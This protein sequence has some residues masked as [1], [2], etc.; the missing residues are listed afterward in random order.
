MPALETRKVV[1]S[2]PREGSSAVARQADAACCHWPHSRGSLKDRS[3]GDAVRA[4]GA[5]L[6]R[7]RPGTAHGF[8]F[9]TL[10]DETGT[11]Q[12]IVPPDLFRANRQLIVTSPLLI[13]DGTLKNATA[14]CR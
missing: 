11:V 4:A 12:A 14:P 1:M 6:V 13:V 9:F 3:D 5:V 2:W 10:E 7:Q 8:V